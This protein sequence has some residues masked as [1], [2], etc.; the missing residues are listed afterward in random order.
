[1][2]STFA[3]EKKCSRGSLVVNKIIGLLSNL[4]RLSDQ[5]NKN[6]VNK[7]TILHSIN[8]LLQAFV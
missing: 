6:Q 3:L 8:I 1:M 4:L 2:W 5:G 7:E